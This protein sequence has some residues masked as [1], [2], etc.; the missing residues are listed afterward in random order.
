MKKRYYVTDYV[1]GIVLT[2][3]KQ[4]REYYIRA[5]KKINGKRKP[6]EVYCGEVKSFEG[7]ELNDYLAQLKPVCMWRVYTN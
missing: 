1:H 4:L 7:S 2:S 3:I 5:T 6:E